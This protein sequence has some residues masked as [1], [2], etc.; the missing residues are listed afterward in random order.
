MLVV[1]LVDRGWS[2]ESPAHSGRRTHPCTAALQRSR[3]ESGRLTVNV[4]WGVR[5]AVGEATQ[6][7]RLLRAARQRLR[8]GCSGGRGRLRHA[9]LTRSPARPGG[10]RVRVEA[11]SDF[12]EGRLTWTMPRGAPCAWWDA[13][14]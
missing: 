8:T 5:R 7:V 9:R 6:A 12:V 11:A 3:P 2:G 4:L 14:A 13:A 10:G 1:G